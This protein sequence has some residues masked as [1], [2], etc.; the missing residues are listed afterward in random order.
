MS[1]QL[2]RLKD[3]LLAI[4]D[5]RA[6]EHALSGRPANGRTQD[7]AT[8][9]DRDRDSDLDSDLD[10]DTDAHLQLHTLAE[11][12]RNL[13]PDYD[14]PAWS[15]AEPAELLPATIGPYRILELLGSGGMGVVY[16]AEQS[17]PLVR[18][19]ALKVIRPGLS[20]EA[21]RARFELERSALARLC[22]PNIAAVLETGAA[23]NGAP[24]VAMELVDGQPITAWVLQNQSS[25][26]TRLELIVAACR[27][28]AHAHARGVIHR[29]IK[30]GNILVGWID[31]RPVPRLID[32]GIARVV[33]TDPEHRLTLTA[34]V[35]G[36]LEY[37]SPE[38]LQHGAAVADSR[39]DVYGLGAILYEL[40]TGHPAVSLEDERADGMLQVVEAVRD[41][42][43]VRP[44]LRLQHPPADHP[45][46]QADIGR[47]L[48]CIILHA[49]QRDPNDRYQSPAEL[50]DD[51]ERYLSHRPVTAHPP[52]AW[53]TGVR[54]LQRHRLIVGMTAVVGLTLLLGLGAAVAGYLSAV[55]SQ[56]EAVAAQHDSEQALRLLSEAAVL[57]NVRDPAV[58]KHLADLGDRVNTLLASNQLQSPR[59]RL[60]LSIMV[61]NAY[62]S[63]GRYA[64][65]ATLLQQALVAA[66]SAEAAAGTSSVARILPEER[67]QLLLLL[68]ESQ[69]HSQQ[70]K[71]ALQTAERAVALARDNGSEQQRAHAE[72]VRASAFV[73]AGEYAQA[74]EIYKW[75]LKTRAPLAKSNPEIARAKAEVMYATILVRQG[76][77]AEAER[78]ARAGYEAHRRHYG[79]STPNTMMS[80][81]NLA[82]ILAAADKHEAAT[83]VF[84][85]VLKARRDRLGAQHPDTLITTAMLGRSLLAVED[86]QAATEMLERAIDDGDAA[87]GDRNPA[88]RL[89]SESLT[90]LSLREQQFERAEAWALRGIDYAKAHYGASDWHVEIQRVRLAEVYL[91]SDQPALA[92]PLCEQACARL[93]TSVGED[94]PHTRAAASRLQRARTAVA[95]LAAAQARSQ[96]DD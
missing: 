40:V 42:E 38:T 45:V 44:S 96:A 94:H 13:P 90:T 11:A 71:Q 3:Q 68:S 29:D 43:I 1:E 83:D 56:A 9:A 95:L 15:L 34:Q 59:V 77:Y 66:S 58:Q 57:S 88:G 74:G 16:R 25:L 87:F 28:L 55:E 35:F 12:A 17:E 76:D 78:Y 7:A 33:D 81:Q 41:A 8:N 31:G 61:A 73:A 91:Q 24:Y 50:A 18:Q 62:Y 23:D 92:V 30:P 93:T 22:H 63:G 60:R 86:P 2:E 48:E 4:V 6:D 5:G 36:T 46:R 65:A 27:G 89:A 69:A 72:F 14:R 84:R 53:T 20:T 67:F 39:S 52:S 54:F 85:D 82:A 64:D 26:R 19:V 75:L 37:V 21:G 47:D 32:F 10:L 70:T 79:M 51:I 80:G 49:L